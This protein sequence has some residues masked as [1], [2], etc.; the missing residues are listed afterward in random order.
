M[1]IIKL[2]KAWR[3]RRA[4]E[5]YA[6]WKA[7]HESLKAHQK[8]ERNMSEMEK[9]FGRDFFLEGDRKD[10]QAKELAE[11]AANEAKLMERVE[12]FMRD[13]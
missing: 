4:Q 9:F 3:L 11:A 10:K 6:Y 1:G 7:R 13:H 8:A 5:Q 2:Y 12:A